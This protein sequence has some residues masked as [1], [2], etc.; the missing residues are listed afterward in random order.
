MLVWNLGNY[1]FFVIAGRSVGPDHY[2]TIAA[3]LAATMLVQ[4][5]AGAVQVGISRR[6]A[7]IGPGDART[8][9]WLVRRAFPRSLG[10]GLLLGGATFAI[11]SLGAPQVPLLAAAATGAAVAPIPAF[12]LAS[13]VLQGHQRFGGFALSIAMLGAPR[14]LALLVLLTTIP[15]VTAAMAAS[16]ITIVLAAVA[17]ATLAWPR[18]VEA[19]MVRPS[20]E[21]AAFRRTI[22]PLAVGLS[23]IGSLINLDVIVA[24]ATLPERIAGLFGAVAVIAKAIVIVPQTVAW[25]LLPRISQTHAAGRSSGR[26]LVLGIAITVI[27]GVTA[28]TIALL[29]GT[30]I[31]EFVF[32]SK[33]GDGAAYLTP[34]FGTASA[35]GL[36]L[37]LMYHQLA[38][39]VD[40]FVWV[41]AG[42]AV[43]EAGAFA[44]AHGSVGVILTIEA[45]VA[46]VGLTLYEVLYGRTDGG[47]SRSI[48]AV[49]HGATQTSKHASAT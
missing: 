16:A 4:I 45:V 47:I 25:V 49:L 12:S 32:G 40:L 5:P 11:V 2:G 6:I 24:R 22:V 17:A 29:F 44:L 42:L 7:E 38:R 20:R 26:L 1:A 46:L 37:V 35:T 19:P 48:R 18:Q 10:S 14:P 31:V 30:P 39:G 43:V 34:M 3:L 15:E 41:V 8:A 28:T 36:L 21:W 9:A 13:G 33:Y 27:G 23:G